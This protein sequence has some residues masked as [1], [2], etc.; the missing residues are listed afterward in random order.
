MKYIVIN[1]IMISLLLSTRVCNIS[2]TSTLDN[3]RSCG[4]RPVLDE[5]IISPS[6]SFMIHFNN[7]YDGIEEFAYNVGIAAD[8]SKTVI[9]DKMNFRSVVPDQD[10]IYD[11][12]IEQLPNG[13]YGWNCPDGDLGQSWVEIDD[14]YIGTNYSTTGLDAMRISVAHEYFHA[15]QR[16][17]VPSPGQNSFFYELSSIWIEDIIFPEI[18]DYI[19]FSQNGDDYF[20]DPEKNMNTYN[21]YGLGLYG[22]YM[23]FIFDDKIMQNI[24]EKFS[25]INTGNEVDFIFNAIDSVLI[26]QDYGY[27]SSFV[28]TWI[29]FNT[30]N[31]FNGRFDNMQNSIYYYEDQKYF[32]P[33]ETNI[34]V[35]DT[36][37]TLNFNID[38]RSVS[39]KSFI[40][41]D[42]SY[43]NLYNNPNYNDIIGLGAHISNIDN[44]YAINNNFQSDILSLNDNFHIV[45][46]SNNENKEFESNIVSTVLNL[47]N[48]SD[49][50]I[51]PNPIYNGNNIT[52]RFNSGI[53]INNIELKLYNINGQLI[54]VKKIGS[55]D[56]TFENFN[57]KTVQLFNN[58]MQS[59]IYFISFNLDGKI[60]N[61]KITFLK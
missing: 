9:I 16:S 30:R 43:F 11:I 22:H 1:F 17:Y 52:F 44:I 36:I 55:L 5:T 2:Y 28:E 8:S 42:V 6:G 38:N 7:Y 47:N 18:N 50:F 25:I 49:I 59:G 10:N 3:N 53:Q 13:S 29:D 32:G 21:G 40:P 45:Y 58:S 20:T 37:E 35:I 39:I 56:Y 12:Y 31:L 54:N 19:F 41:Y 46:I 15:V 14:N 4:E 61:K 26:D 60:I 34:N 24:W 48:S 27:N 51:Y 23:N 33:I 57:Y